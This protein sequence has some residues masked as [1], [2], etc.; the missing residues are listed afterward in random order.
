MLRSSHLSKKELKKLFVPAECYRC[1]G[2]F[3][4]AAREDPC[5]SETQMT[6]II[7]FWIVAVIPLAA[8]LVI[9]VLTKAGVLATPIPDHYRGLVPKVASLLAMGGAVGSLLMV[10]GVGAALAVAGVWLGVLKMLHASVSLGDAVS[11]Y[12]DHLLL[13]VLI[14]PAIAVIGATV[15][16]FYVGWDT[17]PAGGKDGPGKEPP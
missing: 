11:M 13:I 3:A 16:V 7:A 2:D 4:L 17:W 15:M 14:A 9:V 8:I 12:W 5:M 10:P 1:I 6:A